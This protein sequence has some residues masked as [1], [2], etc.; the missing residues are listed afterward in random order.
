MAGKVVPLPESSTSVADGG[1]AM[2]VWVAMVSCGACVVAN[3]SPVVAS[4][5]PVAGRMVGTTDGNVA[6]VRV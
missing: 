6:L 3:G 2:L 4:G 1:G 5:S